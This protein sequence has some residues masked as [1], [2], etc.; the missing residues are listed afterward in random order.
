[1]LFPLR[2]PRTSR[3]AQAREQDSF[4]AI[5]CAAA[6][7]ALSLATSAGAQRPASAP[8]DTLIDADSTSL[9]RAGGANRADSSVRY[10][11]ETF[12][13]FAM[14]TFG[15]VPLLRSTAMAGFDQ[16]RRQPDGWFQNRRG[17]RDR[18]DSRLGAEVLAHTI[19]FGFARAARE[20]QG[21]YQRCVCSGFG[22]RLEYALVS[23][24]RVETPSGEHL[25]AITPFGD[26][27]S[28]LVVTSVHPGGFSVGRGLS[29]GASGLASASLTSVVREFWPWHW[30]P[31]GL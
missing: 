6:L 13:H 8:G 17:L 16:W 22:A 25:S 28:A 26:I 18:L 20:E 5:Q 19:R 31:P 23:P 27:T 7:L 3:S 9:V 15:P 24:F 11:P 29:A 21:K 30:R 14:R 2:P 12:A 4:R 10:Q 1:M